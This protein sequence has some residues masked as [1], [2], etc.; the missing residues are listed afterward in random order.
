MA[1]NW[2]DVGG[3]SGAFG[4][5]ITLAVLFWGFLK[6]SRT[7]GIAAAEKKIREENRVTSVVNDVRELK[8][9]HTD[10]ER[11]IVVLERKGRTS[12]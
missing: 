7:A 9:G 6:N 3:F 1:I 12:R 5:M 10:H 2:G 11:R 4:V 8:H